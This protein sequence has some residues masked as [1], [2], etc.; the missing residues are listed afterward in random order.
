MNPDPELWDDTKLPL[1]IA[2]LSRHGGKHCIDRA[3]NLVIPDRLAPIPQR[4]QTVALIEINFAA[5][6]GDRLGDV[7]Q[8]LADQG[9]GLNRTQP[10]GQARRIVD[11]EKY[12]HLLLHHG[13]I[14]GADH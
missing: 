6:V 8:E 5:P 9:F 13:T 4:D 3:Q 1:K 11:V 7:K 2:S 10:L 14:V 12:Q